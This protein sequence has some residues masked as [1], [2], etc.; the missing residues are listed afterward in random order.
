[1]LYLKN[2]Q[3]EG[4]W[5]FRQWQW[6][7]LQYNYMGDIVWSIP[8]WSDSFHIS[9]TKNRFENVLRWTILF[10]HTQRAHTPSKCYWTHEMIH[11]HNS[12]TLI[13]LHCNCKNIHFALRVCVCVMMCVVSDLI[14]TVNMGE[15][16]LEMISPFS[17]KPSDFCANHSFTQQNSDKLV[18]IVELSIN[19]VCLA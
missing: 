5:Y 15:R 18:F 19:G 8:N 9:S 2:G 14:W 1:M 11:W 4:K 17:I 13:R 12:W 6:L 10:F 16:Q 7:C 3:L